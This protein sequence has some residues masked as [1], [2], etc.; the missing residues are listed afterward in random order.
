MREKERTHSS[1]TNLWCRLTNQ[2]VPESP[3]GNCNIPA[4]NTFPSLNLD[5][6]DRNSAPEEFACI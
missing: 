2:K 1:R 3:V 5:M 4:E 6:V